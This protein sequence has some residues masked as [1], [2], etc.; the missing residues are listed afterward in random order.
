MPLLSF[1]ACT[2]GNLKIER[3]TRA[4][5]QA[6]VSS[7]PRVAFPMLSPRNPLA[8]PTLRGRMWE[9]YSMVTL[10]AGRAMSLLGREMPLTTRSG[11]RE[12]CD[13]SFGISGLRHDASIRLGPSFANSGNSPIWVVS[14]NPTG[15]PPSGYYAR[16]THNSI[17]N[18]PHRPIICL[19]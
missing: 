3:Q 14:K 17:E 2:T 15:S 5:A 8:F 13:K 16:K 6:T 10:G 9:A 19:V 11:W 18:T 12:A 4:R 1:V 7:R